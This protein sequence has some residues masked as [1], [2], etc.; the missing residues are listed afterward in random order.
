MKNSDDS[1]NRAVFEL[2]SGVGIE[3]DQ[4]QQDKVLLA[5]TDIE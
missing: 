1:E 5:S 3:T 2:I 4:Q